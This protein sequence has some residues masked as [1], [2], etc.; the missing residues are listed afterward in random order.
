[1]TE[2]FQFLSGAKTTPSTTGSAAAT[3]GMATGTARPTSSTVATGCQSIWYGT[4]TVAWKSSQNAPTILPGGVDD[5]PVH[6][7]VQLPDPQREAAVVPGAGLQG[8]RGSASGGTGR[9][10]DRLRRRS[11]EEGGLSQEHKAGKLGE[12]NAKGSRFQGSPFQYVMLLFP[13]LL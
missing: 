1:M 10:R 12:R 11:Q 6:G 13:F 7:H 8:Q 5:P 3:S 2:I 4:L 9:A